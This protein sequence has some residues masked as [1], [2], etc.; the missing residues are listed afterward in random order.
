[1]SGRN[2]YHIDATTKWPPFSRRFQTRFLSLKMFC[3]IQISL[4]FVPNCP[5]VHKTTLIQVMAWRLLGAMPLPESVLT[6]GTPAISPSLFHIAPCEGKQQSGIVFHLREMYLGQGSKKSLWYI[7]GKH[8]GFW[9]GRM[10]TDD[11]LCPSVI[12]YR[13]WNWVE[14]GTTPGI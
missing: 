7:P 5:T 14:I 12:A 2:I 10:E 3:L 1:M 13:K 11:C 6:M 8:N 4:N 9:E